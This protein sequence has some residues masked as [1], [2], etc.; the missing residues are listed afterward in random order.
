MASSALDLLF[1]IKA[2]DQASS[3]VK[4]LRS[5]FDAETKAIESSGK[6]SF[7]KLGDSV[8]FSTSQMAGLAKAAPIVGAAVAAAGVAIVGAAVAA[9]AAIFALAKETADYGSKINDA[10]LK[11]GLTAETL[12]GLDLQ[13]KQSGSSVEAFSK[14]TFFMQKYLEAAA[15]GGKEQIRTLK[16]LLGANFDATKGLSDME[17]TT[18]KLFLA[19]GQLEE[20]Q[21]NAIGAKIMSRSFSELSTFIADTNGDIDPLIEKSRELGLVMSQE[22]AASADEFGDKLDELSNRA[23]AAGRTI[24]TVVIPGIMDAIERLNATFKTIPDVVEGATFAANSWIYQWITLPLQ[25]AQLQL[26]RLKNEFGTMGDFVAEALAANE[27][28][29]QGGD[30]GEGLARI[31]RKRRVNIPV[32]GTGGGGADKVQQAANKALAQAVKDAEQIYKTDTENAKRE[33]KLRL[34]SLRDFTAEVIRLENE[35]FT[36]EE[37][38]LNKRIS[39]AKKKEDIDKFQSELTAKRAERDRAIQ[40]ATDE[41][42]QKEIDAAEAHVATL[43]KLYEDFGKQKVD[44]LEKQAE[45]GLITFEEAARQ[46]LEIQDDLYDRKLEDLARQEDAANM[47]LELRQ[48]INDQ[49]RALHQEKEANQNAHD[50]KTEAARQKDLDRELSYLN[51]LYEMSKKSH[52]RRV[53][54][55]RERLQREF[56]RGRLSKELQLFNIQERL[57]IDLNALELERLR[58]EQ[59]ATARIGAVLAEEKDLKRREELLRAHFAAIDLIRAEFAQ[60]EADRKA[61]AGAETSAAN[62][63][64]FF[65][66]LFG[67]KSVEEMTK[68]VSVMTTLGGMM[69]NVFM[70][71]AQAVGQAVKSFVLFGNIGTS[72]RKFAAE[73]IAS[74]AQMAAVQAVW[75]LAQALAMTALAWFT[76]NPKFA[77]AAGAHYSAAAFYG[78][79]AGVAALAGRVVAGNAFQQQGAGGSGGGGGGGGGTGSRGYEAPT[80]NVIEQ[81]RNQSWRKDIYIHLETNEHAII[82]AFERD[83]R[84][85]GTMRQMLVLKGEV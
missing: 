68:T 25:I 17:G 54:L 58:E 3:T 75:E 6:T 52:D 21:R 63:P 77:L 61:V 79:I 49:I 76:G 24:G 4:K 31:T 13:L 66:G 12:S 10:S 7:L 78:A 28:A 8:G 80:T 39:I 20:G 29:E 50:V 53:A 67:T 51:K 48:K 73:V 41:Q 72:F 30:F 38:A 85:N 42:S 18:R 16:A 47:D 82:N 26:I 34:T 15:E 9:G 56:D 40:A 46:E 5:T 69:Q 55:D 36:A 1:R 62:V 23:A 70:G 81:D 2:D 43:L 84:G 22:A 57:R 60:K 59:E 71:I 33:Y 32:G 45:A 11:T 65:G 83:V 74:V 14:A 44:V 27:A 64:D 37:T 19:L 35:R